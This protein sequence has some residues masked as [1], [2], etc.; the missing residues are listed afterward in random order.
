MS[1]LL[2]ILY[3]MTLLVFSI[4]SY[5]FVDPNLFYL[6]K[7]F[8][9]FAFLHREL[10]SFIYL[11]FVFLLFG[12]YCFFLKRYNK[13]KLS[14]K[15]LLKI[16]IAT[17]G[18]F[19][20]AYPAMLSYDIFNYYATAKLTF[21]YKE[22]PYLI[23]PIELKNEPLLRFMHSPNKVALYGPVWILL[24]AFSLLIGFGNFI[25]TLFSLKVIALIFY[26]LTL[27]IIY[28][29]AKNWFSVIL[30]GLHPLVVIETIVSGH[31]DIVMMFFALFSFYLL[32]RKKILPAVFMLILS[33][34]IKYATIVLI[35]VFIFSL[36]KM[37]SHEKIVWHQI[38]LYATVSM[39]FVFFLSPLREE[40]YPWYAIWFLSFG[41][42]IRRTRITFLLQSLS[43][44]L[45][46][47]Y[48]PFM[49]TGT[50]FGNTPILRII[51]TVIPIVLMLCYIFSKSIIWPKR[52]LR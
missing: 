18:I 23:M 16:I 46:L 8:T 1:K 22:N 43:F 39:A 45:L 5:L 41:S 32:Q 14:E 51:L 31:N 28:K 9:G 21:F 37:K 24:T 29:M 15:L 34:L 49:Y 6:H 13:K 17:A 19:F 40:M 12:W 35:P 7:I 2:F 26:F 20:F 47:R 11:I 3:I 25:I 27:W 10:T 42:L 30:F 38:F 50:Y 44:G 36:W 33:I 52:F 4:F 48:L